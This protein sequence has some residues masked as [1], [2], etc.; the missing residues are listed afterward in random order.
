MI[1]VDLVELAQL[2]QEI[3]DCGHGSH[4]TMNLDDELDIRESSWKPARDDKNINNL[5]SLAC[6]GDDS[7]DHKRNS[8]TTSISSV[9]S[10]SN[11]TSLHLMSHNWASRL[12]E[13]VSPMQGSINIHANSIANSP[14]NNAHVENPVTRRRA[15]TIKQTWPAWLVDESFQVIKRKKWKY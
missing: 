4:S 6:D 12:S 8:L 1:C 9:G 13:R 3:I 10:H 15:T 2:R 7:N 14:L 5:D 11:S